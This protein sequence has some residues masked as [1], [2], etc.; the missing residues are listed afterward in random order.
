MKRMLISLGVILSFI[1][2]SSAPAPVEQAKPPAEI[3]I[4]SKSPEAIEHFKKGR[5]LVDNQ[6]PAE[7]VLELDQAVKLDPDFA[8]GLRTTDSR[9]RAGTV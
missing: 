9:Y 1:S 3:P 4:T 8:L 6:R 5:D 2:C 7:A